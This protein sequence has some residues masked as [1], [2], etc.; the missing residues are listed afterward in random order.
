MDN[1]N[2]GSTHPLLEEA[3]KMG[4]EEVAQE[5]IGSSDSPSVSFRSSYLGKKAIQKRKMKNKAAKKARKRNR[6]RR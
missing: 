1:K 5:M 6:N 3:K 2:S 4:V